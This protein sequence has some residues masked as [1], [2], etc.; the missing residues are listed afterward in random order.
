MKLRSSV[1]IA[2]AAALLLTGAGSSLAQST[3]P[4]PSSASYSGPQGQLTVNS[5]PAPATPAG[6]A[7]DFAQLAGGKGGITPDQ[8]TAYPPLAND[9]GYADSNH[10]GR[11]SKAEYARWLKHN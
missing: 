10:D 5:V 6:P 11:V 3:Q 7:P 1:T 9:F 2:L 8:A 4:A